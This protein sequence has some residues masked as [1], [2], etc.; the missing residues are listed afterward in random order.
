[1][2]SHLKIKEKNLRKCSYAHLL[3]RGSDKM[4][5]TEKKGIEITQASRLKQEKI[6]ASKRELNAGVGLADALQTLTMN[7]HII[8]KKSV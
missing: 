2:L 5:L 3:T 7:S 4:T 8:D 1:M 6:T